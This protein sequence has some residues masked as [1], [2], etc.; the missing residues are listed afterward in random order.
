M[1]MR[2]LRLLLVVQVALVGCGKQ[3]APSGGV[4]ALTGSAWNGTFTLKI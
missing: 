3:E 4:Q 2:C 1:V